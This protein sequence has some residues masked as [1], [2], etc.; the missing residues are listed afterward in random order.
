MLLQTHPKS[1][2]CT[3]TPISSDIQQ[4]CIC[5][6]SYEQKCLEVCH[7]NRKQRVFAWLPCHRHIPVLNHHNKS[8]PW[9]ACQHVTNITT[10][11]ETDISAGLT[12]AKV[13]I[14]GPKTVRWHTVSGLMAPRAGVQKKTVR[15]SFIMPI[16]FGFTWTFLLQRVYQD[17][18]A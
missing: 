2:F 12:R 5:T 9:H 6:S 4:Q 17:G 1:I 7:N 8:H 18:L 11:L 10:G 3:H 13:S 15:Q 16:N 14:T